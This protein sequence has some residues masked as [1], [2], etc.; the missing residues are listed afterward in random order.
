MVLKFCRIDL[1]K[2]RI[3]NL[4]YRNKFVELNTYIRFNTN[5][6]E[7]NRLIPILYN[8]YKENVMIPYS[9]FIN[10]TFPGKIEIIA[11]LGV[12]MRLSKIV[13]IL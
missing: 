9:I 6:N 2:H 5:I 8:I 4:L 13:L 1:S 10:I 11:F 7:Y 12:L 3:I